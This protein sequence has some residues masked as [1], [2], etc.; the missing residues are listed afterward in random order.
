M[1]VWSNWQ[2]FCVY[3]TIS[4]CVF[5]TY[6]AWSEHARRYGHWIKE[7]IFQDL[8][9][10]GLEFLIR[11]ICRDESCTLSLSVE[12]AI[13]DFVC[14]FWDSMVEF[15]CH[16]CV[17]IFDVLIHLHGLRCKCKAE[18]RDD[19]CCRWISQVANS[20][21][22]GTSSCRSKLKCLVSTCWID[23]LFNAI[24]VISICCLLKYAN[25]FRVLSLHFCTIYYPR[26]IVA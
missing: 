22:D 11:F 25:V 12:A 9:G 1:S 6:L 8:C 19:E 13:L 20:L 21:T 17:H 24:F 10:L 14:R 7:N 5:E 3:T 15:V 4:S 18:R 2:L 26:L 23:F 16:E